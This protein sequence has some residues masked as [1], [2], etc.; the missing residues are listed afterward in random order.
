MFAT[1]FAGIIDAESIATVAFDEP[2]IGQTTNDVGTT[3]PFPKIN[4]HWSTPSPVECVAT[5]PLPY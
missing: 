4:V 5:Y 3:L 1:T 2:L